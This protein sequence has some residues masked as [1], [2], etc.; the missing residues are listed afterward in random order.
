[1]RK[2]TL[3]LP[4]LAVAACVAACGE[5]EEPPTTTPVTIQPTTNGGGGG[6]GQGGGQADLSPSQQ[7]TRAVKDVIGSGD[8]G[9]ACVQL[10]TAK[11]VKAAYGSEQGCKAAVSQQGSFDVA[12]DQVKVQGDAAT[13]KAKPAGGPNKGETLTAKLVLQGK[14][15]RVDSLRSNAPAGP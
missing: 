10:V 15:W 7:V 5:K 13:A 12:V 4:L 9:P 14:T 2:L 8:V 3:V 11:Y 6:G 1:M